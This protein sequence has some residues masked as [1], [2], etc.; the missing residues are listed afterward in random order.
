[1]ADRVQIQL[2]KPDAFRADADPTDAPEPPAWME[3][4]LQKVVEQELYELFD[5]DEHLT[6][7]FVLID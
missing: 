3:E 5:I 1:M 6:V 4:G 7:D 2:P